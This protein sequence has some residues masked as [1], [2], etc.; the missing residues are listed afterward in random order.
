MPLNENQQAAVNYIEGPLLVLA[1]PGTGKTQLLS[2]KV[3]HILKVTDTAPNN[4]LC[5]T[6]TE[7][8]AE[9]MRTR[10]LSM[11][12]RDAGKVNIYTYHAFG[13]YIL[14]LYKNYAET[15]DR[16]L[17]SPIDTVIQFRYIQDI[18]AQLPA[19]DIL[20]NDKTSDIVDTI[21]KVKSARLT[22]DD[23]AKIATDNL[24][25]ASQ[26][27]PEIQA[28][29][30]KLVPRMKFDDAIEQVY[31]PLCEIFAKYTKSEPIAQNITREVNE[32]LLEL[33]SI[34]DEEQGK[35]KPSV[36]ELTAWKNK[37]I[38][39]DEA[40]NYRLKNLIANKKLA[41]L[42]NIMAQYD[43]KLRDNGLFDF[44]DMIEEAIKALKNDKGFRATMSEYFQYI[45]LDE[46]QDTNPSQAELVYLLT[47]YE[48]PCIMAVGDDDQAIYEFQGANASNLLEF[49]EHYDAKVINL[50]DNYRSTSEILDFSHR[51][52]EN[53]NNSFAKSHN[54][55]K[56]L[57]SMKEL[58][59]PI[60]K[61]QISR[62][63]FL[64][65][66]AEYYWVADQID[67]LIKSGVSQSDIAIITRQHK[68]IAPIL[69]YL[70]AHKNINIA[71]EKRDNLFDDQRIR[72]LFTLAEFVYDLSNGDQPSHRLLEILSFPYWKIDPIV[73]I[74]ACSYA[75]DAKK[76]TLDYLLK[77]GK[78][79]LQDFARYISI[80]VVH[81]FDTPL[82]LFID[83]LTGAHSVQF[84][85]HEFKSPYFNYY[86]ESDDYE[87]FEFY[88]LLNTLRAAVK[89]HTHAERPVLKDLIEFY[90]DYQA[91]NAPL[92]STSPYQD[93]DDAVQILSAHKA[94]GLEFEYVFII[95]ADNQ[96][97]GGGKGNNNFLTLPANLT[98]IRHTGITDDERLR[99]LFV[100]ITRAKSHL[101][102]TNSLTDF[103][104]KSPARLEYFGEYEDGD[105]I[106]SPLIPSQ[107][108][109][110]HYDDL[111]S[112]KHA[113]DLQKSWISS[114]TKLTPNLAT[115]LKQRVK[116]FRLSAT[117]ITT[118]IDL[119]HAGPVKFYKQKILH[120]PPEPA[121][122]AIVFGNLIHA[123]FEKVTKEHITDDEAI[124][125]FRSEAV[126]QPIEPKELDNLLERGVVS[127]E[128]SL[129]TFAP[130]LRH[131]NARAEI[132]LSSDHITFQDIPILGVIDHINIDE[133]NKTI[134]VY[135]F[136]TGTFKESGWN[137]DPSLYKYKFQLE[138]YK[139]L[140][141]LSPTFSKYTI[142]RGHLLFV[143]PDKKLGEV[144]DKV[145]EYNDKDEAE[146]KSLIKAI[147]YH[148][149]SLDFVN[150]PS[151]F[152]ET[153][154]NTSLS[155]IKA[156]VKFLIEDYE[157]IDNTKEK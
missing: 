82:E 73:A 45:L 142:T 56:I 137:S 23:L 127:L 116:N 126:K 76:S 100:A 77:S 81:S 102:I 42:A 57:R 149:T 104:G 80:L 155:Q 55:A 98:Q 146:L 129:K 43:K 123:T 107:T 99:L 28:P 85:D 132:N 58:A 86:T 24:E 148:I 49:Q 52:A 6:F 112:A 9:N 103:S 64:S 62:D 66:D 39:K 156:F 145:Y 47:D 15:F 19:M 36:R 135:D 12:G 106:V 113:T 54:I 83:Y 74:E 131:E 139:L 61:T 115:I 16:N 96:S 122:E 109:T 72:E 4:I 150:N 154:Q 5:L 29:L 11:I 25:V 13:S 94:K 21:Q 153:D 92:T 90:H 20:R 79:E 53:I 7:S 105:K 69:P 121:T 119:T 75:R 32:Y 143:S 120:M 27:T 134:E 70:K 151:I 125:F 8:G 44:A 10:L 89:S 68:Y 128:T 87:T 93:S 91:A 3:A 67:K 144:H 60:A 138:F 17:D 136:K 1:G 124:E 33:N 38:E 140:L 133:A 63:E 130:I 2:S 14:S 110:K 40:G 88:E 65:A 31:R 152:I 18:Q 117:D 51:I 48:K 37:R 26:L 78:P 22:A 41:S 71:Y 95:A 147:Y 141:N 118:F 101:Y 157:A 114:Y 34:I 46:F 35:E 97:W 30:N 84:E 50:T 59:H 108:V 111:D